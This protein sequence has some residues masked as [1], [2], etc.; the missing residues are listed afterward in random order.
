MNPSSFASVPAPA[1]TVN[2]CPECWLDTSA[3][4]TFFGRELCPACAR[5]EEAACDAAQE[6]AWEE[7]DFGRHD[8]MSHIGSVLQG[9]GF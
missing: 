2:T 9:M 5:A 1:E 7:M 6:A 3:V 4:M 8:Q